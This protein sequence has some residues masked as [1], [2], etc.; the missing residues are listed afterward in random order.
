MRRI[1]F[2]SL[3]VVVVGVWALTLPFALANQYARWILDPWSRP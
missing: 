3:R 2:A 1:L